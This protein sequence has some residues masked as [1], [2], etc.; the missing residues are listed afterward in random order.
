M[1]GAGKCKELLAKYPDY[2]VFWCS[3]FQY[4]GKKEAE[5]PRDKT[6]YKLHYRE[7]FYAKWRNATF[8]EIM[9]SHYD[10]AAAI[11]IDVDHDKREL[12]FN[13]FSEN[14]MF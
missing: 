12:H 3:G 7:G 1:R 9:Q 10:W 6:D 14:D 2:K 8:E 11:D 13:G 4:R 5:M